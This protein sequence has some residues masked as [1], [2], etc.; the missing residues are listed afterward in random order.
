MQPVLAL[1]VCNAAMTACVQV[2]SKSVYLQYSTRQEIGSGAP[3]PDTPGSVL[4]VIMDNIQASTMIGTLQLIAMHFN[5]NEIV[6]IIR[7]A[8]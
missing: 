1:H 3:M 4:L 2:R 7:Q 5:S 6:C 8:F